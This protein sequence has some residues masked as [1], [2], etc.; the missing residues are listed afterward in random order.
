MKKDTPNDD[1]SVTRVITQIISPAI[2]RVTTIQYTATEYAGV[3][4]KE[5]DE[6]NAS[7]QEAAQTQTVLTQSQTNA[8]KVITP[9]ITPPIS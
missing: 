4:Q 5:I 8:A 7:E 2:T 9:P 1:G 3:A 6:A